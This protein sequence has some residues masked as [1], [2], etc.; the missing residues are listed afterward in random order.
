MTDAQKAVLRRELEAALAK[1]A[2]E[3]ER[4]ETELEPIA[5]DCCLGDLTRTELMAEQEI[6]AQ[7]HEAAVRR[8]NRLKYALA[9]MDS[10]TYGVCEACGEPIAPARLALLPEAT[11]CVACADEKGR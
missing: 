9:R 4:L 3:I 6:C 11:L 10:E 5:P 7:A 2:G 1:T 8:R